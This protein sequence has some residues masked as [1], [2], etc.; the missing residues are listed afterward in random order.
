MTNCT[1]ELMPRPRLGADVEPKSSRNGTAPTFPLRS[2]SRLLPSPSSL[3]SP[4]LRVGT[5]FVSL[6]DWRHHPLNLQ[7]TVADLHLQHPWLGIWL[8][9]FSPSLGRSLTGNFIA[10]FAGFSPIFVP[11]QVSGPYLNQ[12]GIASYPSGPA[13]RGNRSPPSR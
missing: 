11:R 5:R 8:S 9:S 2:R 10:E 7:V 13:V 1:V 4:P 3:P 6:R 12:H